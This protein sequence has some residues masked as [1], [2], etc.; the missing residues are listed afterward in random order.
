MTLFY[1]D[2]SAILKGYKSEI[3]SEFVEELMERRGPGEI[4]ASSATGLF[5]RIE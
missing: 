1:L 2:T 3:G 5:R 4:L